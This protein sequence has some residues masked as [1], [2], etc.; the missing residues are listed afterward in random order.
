MNPSIELDRRRNTGECFVD[1]IRLFRSYAKTLIP[2][3][4]VLLLPI[5][6]LL[7]WAARNMQ[8]G[9]SPMAMN[10]QDL[11]AA[12]EIL[13]SLPLLLLLSLLAHSIVLSVT[14]VRLQDSRGQFKGF[15]SLLHASL[16]R[17]TRNTLRLAG[18]GIL[19]LMIFA[20]FWLF[21]FLLG[22]LLG[23]VAH[24]LSIV[25]MILLPMLLML[26]IG[27]A[28]FL[29]PL[30]LILD[31]ESITDSITLSISMQAR[32]PLRGILLMLACSLLFL[33]VSLAI[34]FPIY[35]QSIPAMISQIQQGIPP[36]MPPTSGA[37]FVYGL[38]VVPLVQA[39]QAL[40]WIQFSLHLRSLR[41]G[42]V[43]RG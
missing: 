15:G 33:V 28:M 42:E 17:L 30:L 8:A 38:L 31:D 25:T 3:L 2:V 1:G 32:H 41:H 4:L 43:F 24:W 40:L 39:L 9:S 11:A 6:T 26:W 22:M 10:S 5:N 16:A 14:A 34:G 35:I 23:M 19:Q 21:A 27:P 18:L 36:V 29:A 12:G 20:L 37:L 13:L 7:Q